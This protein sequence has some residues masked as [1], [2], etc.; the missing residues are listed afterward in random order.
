MTISS[1]APTTNPGGGKIPRKRSWG[2]SL[3]K[4]VITGAVVGGL[5]RRSSLRWDLGRL[6]HPGAGQ[7]ASPDVFCSGSCLRG[8]GP[9]GWKTGSRLVVLG[10][11]SSGPCVPAV[12]SGSGYGPGVYRAHVVHS[13]RGSLHRPRN[14]RRDGQMGTAP[15]VSW[16]PDREGLSPWRSEPAPSGDSRMGHAG[17][18][19]VIPIGSFPSRRQGPGLPTEEAIPGGG[20]DGSG[21][22]GKGPQ[23]HHT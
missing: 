2:Q 11:G 8:Q 1:L 23:S 20:G 16:S 7:D 5:A 21:A 22:R 17:S 6:S 13:R 4:G 3:K 18:G 15:S 9:S 19:E 14:I 12:S 10:A